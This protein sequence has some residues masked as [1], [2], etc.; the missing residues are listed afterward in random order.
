MARLARRRLADIGENRI[1]RPLKIFN[2]A[3]TDAFEASGTGTQFQ[4][5]QDRTQP[6]LN[7]AQ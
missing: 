1:A 6:A 4:T 3:Q 2:A 7:T 5:Q